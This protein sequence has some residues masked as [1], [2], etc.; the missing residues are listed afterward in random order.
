MEFAESHPLAVPPPQLPI[1]ASE[2]V[3]TGSGINEG[4]SVQNN[5]PPDSEKAE[6]ISTTTAEPVAVESVIRYG[7][8]SEEPAGI[9]FDHGRN[10]FFNVHILIIIEGAPNVVKISIK[11]LNGKAFARRYLPSALVEELFR[12]AESI[13]PA[14]ATS[15]RRF[16]LVTRF[17]THSCRDAHSHNNPTNMYFNFRF[18]AA[19]LLDC[20]H[21]TI[22]ECNLSGSQIFFRW[23]D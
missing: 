15:N 8:P 4:S 20:I 13:E 21:K 1:P 5:L 2:V 23:L 11:L 12:V 17:V 3:T 6:F 9:V 10:N 19:S 7:L 22:G 18:P 16:E 14:V